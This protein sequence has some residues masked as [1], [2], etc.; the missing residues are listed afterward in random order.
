M[1]SWIVGIIGVWFWD[2]RFLEVEREMKEEMNS[3][4]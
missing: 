2:L 3:E 4:E 1:A